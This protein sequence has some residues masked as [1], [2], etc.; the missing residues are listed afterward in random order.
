MVG[1]PDLKQ[2]DDSL[3]LLISSSEE[4]PV[5]AKKVELDL[6][7]APFLQADKESVPAPTHEAGVPESGEEDAAKAKARRKKLLILVIGGILLLAVAAVAIWWF[8]FRVP[9]PPGPAPL[10]P[11]VVVVPRAPVAAQSSE[12][13]R[14]FAPFIVPVK[15]ASGRESFLVCKF[16]AITKD[17]N[18]NR[19]IDQQRIALRDAIF[20]YLRSKDGSYLQD[21]RNADAI[22][23]DLL[24]V[25]ND[26]LTQG[27]LEDILFETYLSH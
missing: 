18:V 16:S 12:I 20:F 3:D 8:M 27:K 4:P 11:E 7:D 13:V 17:Q 6:D 23:K 10:E 9:P 26:Y 14:D 1:Q 21:S 5:P 2:E 19:E 15:D 25:F 24:A 22:R